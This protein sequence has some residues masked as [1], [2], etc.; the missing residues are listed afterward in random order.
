MAIMMIAMVV[1]LAFLGSMQRSESFASDRTDALDE[2]RQGVNRLTR[3]GRQ[4]IVISPN[5]TASRLEMTTYVSGAPATVVWEASGTRLTRIVDGSTGFM[6]LDNLAS[7]NLFVYSPSVA[8]A[9]VVE[10]T[11]Q[12]VPSHA[13]DTTL[14]LTS[15]IRPRNRSEQ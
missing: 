15:E 12:V 3:D 8:D 5:S 6:V 2:M 13:P 4:A 9:Q 10:V 11:V 14:E 7:T 1:M